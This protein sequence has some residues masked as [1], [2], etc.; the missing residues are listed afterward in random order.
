MN[1]SGVLRCRG[2]TA[3]LL[4]ATTLC[5]AAHPASPDAC[6]YDSRGSIFGSILSSARAAARGAAG[7]PTDTPG[8][9]SDLPPPEAI[10]LFGGPAAPVGGAPATPAV[11]PVG[12]A[13]A[14]PVPLVSPAPA[15]PNG[16]L[17][18]TDP[19]PG[20]WV[21][22]SPAVARRRLL[23]FHSHSF[24]MLC[25]LGLKDSFDL[26]LYRDL[27]FNTVIVDSPWTEISNFGTQDAL[28]RSARRIGLDV[29]VQLH[30]GEPPASWKLR[31]DV[32]DP[33]Y[34]R[35]VRHY[36]HAAAAHFME[37][38]NLD[39]YMFEDG[40]E[41]H[42]A[43]D[44]EGF[45]AF[46]SPHYANLAV[47]NSDWGT[48]FTAA[49]QVTMDSA[50]GISA[51][52][53][54]GLSLPGLLVGE[55]R[56]GAYVSL[57]TCWAISMRTA[58]PTRPILAGRQDQPRAA[59]LVPHAYAGVVV[60]ASPPALL[61]IDI[62]RRG[63]QQSTIVSLPPL[64]LA[65]KDQLTQFLNECV[66]HGA[67][68]VEFPSWDAIVADRT[69]Q[70]CLQPLLRELLISAVRLR[71]PD[72]SYAV[73]YEP[74]SPGVPEGGPD[75]AFG[76]MGQPGD[77]EPGRL[78]GVL[79]RGSIYGFP[80]VLSVED[81][82]PAILARYRTILLPSV[83]ALPAGS[84]NVLADYVNNGGVVVADLGFDLDE[85]RFLLNAWPAASARLFGLSGLSAVQFGQN[86][87]PPKNPRQRQPAGAPVWYPSIPSP[88]LFP[89][90][91][92]TVI[93]AVEAAPVPFSGP[94]GFGVPVPGADV[95][96]FGY[97]PPS[98]DASTVSGVF[99]RRLGRG[100]AVFATFRL[101]SQWAPDN[102]LFGLFHGDLAGRGAL[103]W[104]DAPPGIP[105]SIDFSPSV[106]GGFQLMQSARMAVMA[107]THIEGAPH[108]LRSNCIVQALPTDP[109]TGLAFV[110]LQPFSP[111]ACD[112]LPITIEPER[113]FT[114]SAVDEYSPDRIRLKICG[115]GSSVR[116]EAGQLHLTP[117]DAT[118]ASVLVR[119]GLYSVAP[120][121]RHV[122]VIHDLQAGG[123][124]H[125]IALV[126]LPD[127]SILF[128]GHF[129]ASSIEILPVPQE[130]L[131]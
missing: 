17:P 81:L 128:T 94:R 129:I 118:D 50:S 43:L 117:H 22:D 88:E 67:A 80:D 99:V 73:V 61:P 127:G 31:V 26:V 121:S 70:A 30:P 46:L 119:D 74:L 103:S 105:F 14:A 32:S 86:E 3:C 10:P 19:I 28:A 115:T 109:P 12:G 18:D 23:R 91:T 29:V 55:Y 40:S 20:V 64:D 56:A 52:Q 108:N 106:G 71:D 45:R 60:S 83:F 126:A 21:D 95:V 79:S 85:T 33:L 2:R 36:L 84:L 15:A 89:D 107:T 110:A 78:M 38:G 42:T 41:Q 58:D 125:R 39:A 48:N 131:R 98:R 123:T 34:V 47:L 90:V 5:M 96:V 25:A 97:N 92:E 112:N 7:N 51:Q 122:A 63:G 53:Y 54:D 114:T 16:P 59:V 65:N 72:P 100:Y 37:E 124:T 69:V 57:L 49:A 104:V 75:A 120:G 6:D 93:R 62:A 27:G 68:G 101:W 113:G 35:A 44:N 130:P 76:Y 11:P 1:L 9:G 116:M 13:P 102:A 66:L 8:H 4:L 87:F 111:V 82:A 77:S 24:V